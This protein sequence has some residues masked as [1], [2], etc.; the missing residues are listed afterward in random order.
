MVKKSSAGFVGD[1]TCLEVTV[2]CGTGF[3]ALLHACGT[4]FDAAARVR[5]RHGEGRRR[6]ASRVIAPSPLISTRITHIVW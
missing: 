2:G 1:A 5:C 3:D 4:G 6:G